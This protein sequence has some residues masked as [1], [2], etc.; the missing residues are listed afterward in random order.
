MS[1]ETGFDPQAYQ[2]RHFQW[3]QEGRVGV[4]TLNRP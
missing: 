4:V 1:A 3:R 2:A